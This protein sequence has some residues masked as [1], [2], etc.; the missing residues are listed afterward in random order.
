MHLG[1]SIYETIDEKG[2][3]PGPKPEKLHNKNGDVAGVESTW[4]FGR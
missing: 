2:F 1:V 3:W 4:P